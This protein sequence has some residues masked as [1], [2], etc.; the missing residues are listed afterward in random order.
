[1]GIGYPLGLTRFRMGEKI[2]YGTGRTTD[3]PPLRGILDPCAACGWQ[4]TTHV[5]V[6][7]M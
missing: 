1:M 7:P 2:I 4:G 6:L 3:L 5:S